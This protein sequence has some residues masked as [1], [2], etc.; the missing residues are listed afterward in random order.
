MVHTQ[1]LQKCQVLN[2]VQNSVFKSSWCPWCNT[3]QN[4]TFVFYW[5][6]QT[7]RKNIHHSQERLVHVLTTVMNIFEIDECTFLLSCGFIQWMYFPYMTDR[8]QRDHCGWEGKNQGKSTSPKLVFD[9]SSW[10]MW[11]CEQCHIASLRG[12]W[13]SWQDINP[14]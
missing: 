3:D 9:F 8:L 10:Q 7:C 2:Q 6:N 14:K 11:Q 4:Q 13:R 12:S 1:P 5:R